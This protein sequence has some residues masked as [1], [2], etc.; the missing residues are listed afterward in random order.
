MRVDVGRAL[1]DLGRAQRAAGQDAGVAF[2]RA[3]DLFVACDARLFLPEVEA[4]L[5]G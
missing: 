4:E 2:E 5:E 1:L 3:R